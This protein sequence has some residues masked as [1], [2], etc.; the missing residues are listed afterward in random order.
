MLAH[1]LSAPVRSYGYGENFYNN[2][3]YMNECKNNQEG[4]VDG[5]PD[6]WK[7]DCVRDPEYDTDAPAAGASLTVLFPDPPPEPPAPP[8]D[9][10]APP[11]HPPPFLPTPAM[12]PADVGFTFP[13][14]QPTPPPPQ[15]P[16]FMR[17]R[18]LERLESL[19]G[20]TMHPGGK[21]IHV[22]REFTFNVSSLDYIA[23]PNKF[24]PSRCAVCSVCSMYFLM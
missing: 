3:P 21:A 14:P 23:P 15:P 2:I 13:S 17:R 1:L 12:A 5:V 6:R 24:F 7:V 4:T 19:E 11:P 18:A 22:T 9:P 20:E 10:P 8:P 16:G